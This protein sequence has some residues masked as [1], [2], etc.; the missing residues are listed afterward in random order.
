MFTNHHRGVDGRRERSGHRRVYLKVLNHIDPEPRQSSSPSAP[1][2]SLDHSSRSYPIRF[3]DGASTP[4]AN[5]Q[6]GLST[7]RGRDETLMDEKTKA[8]V[9]RQVEQRARQR[10]R[11]WLIMK[12]CP[13]PIGLGCSASDRNDIAHETRLFSS[14][15]KQSFAP[16]PRP[17]HTLALRQSENLCAA[18]AEKLNLSSANFQA[19][20]GTLGWVVM[21]PSMYRVARL[22]S[23]PSPMEIPA[24]SQQ[25]WGYLGGVGQPAIN[26]AA[27]NFVA[28]LRNSSPP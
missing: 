22:P 28:L 8:M 2:R 23:P 27:Q 17:R 20:H 19:P 5:G 15:P 3:E 12:K 6:R 13:I 25:R 24:S 18:H 4:P 21:G 16:G 26:E 10:A 9:R 14:R 1:G 7:V 11:H